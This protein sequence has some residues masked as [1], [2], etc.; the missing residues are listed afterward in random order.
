MIS[1]NDYRGKIE[2][3]LLPLSTPSEINVLEW[4]LCLL[5][6]VRFEELKKEKKKILAKIIYSKKQLETVY[7]NFTDMEVKGEREFLSCPPSCP[8]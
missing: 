5:G 4:R 8:S 3:F 7:I 2:L 1:A 6:F